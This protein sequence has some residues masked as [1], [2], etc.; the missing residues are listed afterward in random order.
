MSSE[1]LNILIK[2]KQLSRI[3]GII[4]LLL[5]VSDATPSFGNDTDVH[6]PFSS[7]AE[8]MS[9]FIRQSIC[10]TEIR[11]SGFIQLFGDSA[12]PCIESTLNSIENDI[13]RRRAEGDYND[14]VRAIAFKNWARRDVAYLLGEI[15][16][17]KGIPLLMEIKNRTND[18]SVLEAV[19]WAENNIRLG[20]TRT[21][22]SDI[23]IILSSDTKTYISGEDIILSL[24]LKNLAAIDKQVINFDSVP[25]CIAMSISIMAQDGR[26]VRNTIPRDLRQHQPSDDI[27]LNPSQVYTYT[28]NVSEYFDLTHPGTYKILQTFPWIQGCGYSNVVTI[29]I[30]QLQ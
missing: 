13:E 3:I 18:D 17:E 6:Y 22:Q 12:I 27:I 26:I 29:S 11:P 24:S 4:G 21:I 25:V 23:E 14:S 15:A 20:D 28:F 9:W 1:R 30:A 2:M 16:S 7:M 19:D 10:Q 5:L 8:R